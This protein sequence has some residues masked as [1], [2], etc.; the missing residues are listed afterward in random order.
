MVPLPQL[1]FISLATLLCRPAAVS[2][3]S[4]VA[5]QPDNWVAWAN[6]DITW[7]HP[8][9]LA[10]DWVGAWL[11]A[12]N[13]TY[14]KWRP[15][16]SSPSWQAGRGN[17]SFRL[18]NG[19][20]AYVFRYFR[21]DT[22][23]AESNTIFPVG[24][25][26]MQGHLSLVPGQA[27]RMAVSWVSDSAAGKAAVLWGCSADNLNSTTPAVSDTYTAVDFT[28]CMGI[29]PIKPLATAF[30]NLS[31]HTIS[32]GDVCCDDPTA[33][34]LFLDP[35]YMHNAVLT[36]LVPS[37][38]YYYK[39]GRSDTGSFSDV[40]VLPHVA[41]CAA[42]SLTPAPAATHFWPR[43]SPATRPTSHSCAPC[44]LHCAVP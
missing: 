10:S 3:Q 23:L 34:L 44:S 36:P 14:V 27:N 41:V 29:A 16:S 40:C 4:I 25:V 38:R 39:F 33:S 1:L 32:C 12:W 22:V 31:L 24:D 19:R 28:N 8:S 9:P 2:A 15:V 26:P 5:I 13:A 42:H 21:G 6:V 17:M 18:L 35:G 11:P 30:S 20:H 37:Q 43:A 7:S